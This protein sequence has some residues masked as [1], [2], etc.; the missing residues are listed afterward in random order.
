M[1]GK[2]ITYTFSARN[3]SYS[4]Q[5]NFSINSIA[6]DV[7]NNLHGF[8][9]RDPAHYQRRKVAGKPCQINFLEN[10]ADYGHMNFKAVPLESPGFS[11][12]VIP[13]SEYQHAKYQKNQPPIGV[14]EISEGYQPN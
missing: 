10:I 8:N 5:N 13:K 12:N 2:T 7:A 1:P 4:L 9:N 11:A 6:N 14:K 3:F